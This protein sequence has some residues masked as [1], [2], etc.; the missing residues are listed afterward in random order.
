MRIQNQRQKQKPLSILGADGKPIFAYFDSAATTRV[1]E[2]HWSGAVGG[3]FMN[4]IRGDLDILRRRARYE[5]LN[6][7]YGSGIA[8]TLAFDLVGSGPRPQADSGNPKFDQEVEEKFL[9]WAERCD[10]LGQMNLT[11]ILQMQVALQQ[12][13]AGESL[14]LFK[15]QPGVEYDVSLRLLCVD[16]DRL[17]NPI[18]TVNTDKVKDGIEFDSEGRRMAY[19]VSR[20]LNGMSLASESDR[21][22]E[23]QA[24]HLYRI[25]RPGQ[26]R[27]IPWFAA[28]LE[29]FG[30]LRRFTLAT[31]D[32]AETAADIAGTLEAEGLDPDP[33]I[34]SNDVIELER[35]ALLVT[36][37]G[38]TMKQVKAE[39]PT[40]TY[41]MFKAEILNEIARCVMMPYNVAALNSRDYNYASGR[42]DH[43]KYHRFIETIRSW[44]EHRFLLRIFSQWLSEAYLI[45]GFFTNRP[46]FDQVMR[47][48]QTICWFWPGFKHVD[49]VKEANAEASRLENGTLTLSDAYAEQGFD[50]RRKLAQRA[51]EIKYMRELGLPTVPQSDAKPKNKSE[52]EDDE[53]EEDNAKDE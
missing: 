53:K 7:S 24:I 10:Y 4:A 38:Y 9:L 39:H 33:D 14:T 41:A 35:K 11:E 43:Q 21:V 28:C 23:S 16:I 44:V 29:L 22:T 8:D 36:P 45:E 46:T 18:S 34:Q 20:S 52:P 25:K 17:R 42:L 27:G 1:N 19:H 37:P 12:C 49:P 50:W 31:L 51:A 3:E 32:A 40:T 15:R 2:K 48:I 13:E 5:I 6:N 47:A 26:T 30:Q